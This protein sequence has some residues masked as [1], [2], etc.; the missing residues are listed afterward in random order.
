[1]DIGTPPP[2]PIFAGVT[3]GVSHHRHSP[4]PASSIIIVMIVIFS[5]IIVS[6]VIYLL[7]RFFSHRHNLFRTP[8]SRS[9]GVVFDNRNGNEHV[10]EHVMNVTNNGLDSL[11]LFTFS[12]LTG[13]ISGGDC[14]VCLSKFEEADQLR[15]LPLCCHAFHAECVDAWLK[16]NQTC[17]LCRST[18]N[19]TEADIFSKIAASGGSGGNRSNSFRIE[20]GTVSRRRDPS[21]SQRSSNSYSV[22]SFEYVLDE[23]YEIPVELTLRRAVSDLISVDKDSTTSEPPAGQ[24]LGAEMAVGGESGNRNWLRDYVDRLSVSLSSRTISFRDSGRF[25]T[26][27]SR[28]SE[29]VDDFEA[30][31]GRVGEEISEL[32]RWFSGV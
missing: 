10:S 4:P 5:V 31:H 9:N 15:L 2:P 28:R 26:G 24:N 25:F 29:S 19:P 7:I 12:S 16:S 22:G 30:T 1:M 6:A 32:F 23:N 13:K 27:S 18:V 8:I 14:A 21:D 20:I 11:P 17:P 3:P